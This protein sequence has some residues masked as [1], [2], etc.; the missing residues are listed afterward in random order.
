MSHHQITGHTAKWPSFSNH[1][2]AHL[3]PAAKQIL[4]D[5]ASQARAANTCISRHTTEGVQTL[6]LLQGDRSPY[7]PGSLRTA[8]P[9]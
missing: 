2:P 3:A 9:V 5:A 4:A 6:S 8:L 7:E 1:T